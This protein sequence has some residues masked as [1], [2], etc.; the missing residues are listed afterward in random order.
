MAGAKLKKVVGFL[1]HHGHEGG[2]CALRVVLGGLMAA[3]HGWPKL[4]KAFAP[5]PHTFPDIFGMGSEI[6]LYLAI[7]AEFFAALALA[8]G[9][10][11]RISAASLAFVMG[12]AVF[13]VHADDAIFGPGGSEMAA[14][15]GVGFLALAMTGP[16]SWTLP[17]LLERVRK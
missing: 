15:Y 9:I 7:L 2:L 8:A 4:L 16:G 13:V 10:L 3:G 12:T 5:P 6:S 11:A 17:K 1:E 14:L